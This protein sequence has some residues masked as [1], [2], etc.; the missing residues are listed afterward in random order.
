MRPLFSVLMLMCG[1]TIAGGARAD[2]GHEH[3][4]DHFKLM[5]GHA[6][7]PAEE[8]LQPGWY[9]GRCYSRRDP[10][11]EKAGVMTIIDAGEGR[12]KILIPA[13]TV[14]KED[15]ARW[16]EISDEELEFLNEYL[17]ADENP[18]VAPEG[19]SLTSTLSYEG[20]LIGKLH[21][22]AM[23]GHFL[24]KLTNADYDDAETAEGHFFCHFH[25]KVK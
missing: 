17:F 19:K 24:M 3:D 6:G 22:R 13:M 15:P 11:I 9:S 23:H 18:T 1:L 16:D 2:G 7:L 5:F 4:Y 14:S 12:K 10:A 21:T 8:I 20:N 25:K